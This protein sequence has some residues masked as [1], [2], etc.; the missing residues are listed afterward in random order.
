[1]FKTRGHPAGAAAVAED[2]VAFENVELLCI[3]TESK[4]TEFSDYRCSSS[5]RT[6]TAGYR[7]DKSYR[8][9][10]QETRF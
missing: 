2:C 1:M 5:Y 9:Y 8:L 4:G 7:S 10:A 3:V 6:R